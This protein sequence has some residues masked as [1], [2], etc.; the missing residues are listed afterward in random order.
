VAVDPANGVVREHVYLPSDLQKIPPP[1]DDKLGQV[2]YT[3]LV[4]FSGRIT[5]F[6]SNVKGSIEVFTVNRAGHIAGLYSI[7]LPRVAGLKR[8]EEIPTGIAI[9]QDGK[10]LY[11]CGNLSNQLLE[12]DAGAGGRPARL[13]R[14]GGAI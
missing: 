11:V 9:S 10:K 8:K 14:R 7:T 5:N 12:L 6:L 2:S 1:D 4:F 13:E 3:G